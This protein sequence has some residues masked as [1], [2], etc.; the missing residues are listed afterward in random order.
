[1]AQGTQ[2]STHCSVALLP[3]VESAGFPQP[4]V[5]DFRMTLPEAEVNQPSQPPLSIFSLWGRERLQVLYLSSSHR[6]LL[7]STGTG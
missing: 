3:R 7:L 2:G 6:G 1:M 5:A 4:T